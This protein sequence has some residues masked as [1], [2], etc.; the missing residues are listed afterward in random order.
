MAQ[1]M[2]VD[3]A[4]TSNRSHNDDERQHEGR[5]SQSRNHH[6]N[7]HAGSGHRQAGHRLGGCDPRGGPSCGRNRHHS[8]IRRANSGRCVGSQTTLPMPINKSAH[9]VTRRLHQPA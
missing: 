9:S 2:N 5:T 8:Q 4:N 1:S 6:A 3:Q 7:R